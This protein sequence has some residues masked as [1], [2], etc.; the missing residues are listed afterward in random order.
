MFVCFSLNCCVAIYWQKCEL[1]YEKYIKDGK[2]T[3]EINISGRER[4]RLKGLLDVRMGKNEDRTNERLF[5]IWVRCLGAMRT[6]V[7]S[8]L[9]RLQMAN[10]GALGGGIDNLSSTE[11]S[12]PVTST[13]ST[14]Q[15]ITGS[16]NE[17]EMV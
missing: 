14:A 10:S 17:E 13:T 9:T 4:G 5:S 16:G 1:L 8:S 7:L 2:A 11:L 3:F 15:T 6:F 12:C